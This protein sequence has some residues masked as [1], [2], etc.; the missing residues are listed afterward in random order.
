MTDDLG[1]SETAASG[2]NQQGRLNLNRHDHPARPSQEALDLMG[3]SLTVLTSKQPL[4]ARLN[5]LAELVK[6]GLHLQGTAF[7][8]WDDDRETF[9]LHG[10]A[11]NQGLMGR[12]P[13]VRQDWWSLFQSRQVEHELLPTPHDLRLK[14]FNSGTALTIPLWLQNHF[15]GV[16]TVIRCRPEQP[17]FSPREINLAQM[18]AAQTGLA[19]G[20][21]QLNHQYHR[22]Q[23]EAYVAQTLLQMAEDIETLDSQAE[24]LDRI[25]LIISRALNFRQTAIFLWDEENNAYHLA[26]ATGLPAQNRPSWSALSLSQQDLALW[27]LE[28]EERTI[29]KVRADLHTALVKQLEGSFKCE[30]SRLIPLIVK[31]KLLGV[32]VAADY[33]GQ[34]PYSPSTEFFLKGIGTQAAIALNDVKLVEAL[35]RAFWDVIKSL[36]TTIEAKDH[37]THSHSQSVAIYGTSLA[38]AL[39]LPKKEVDKIAKACLLHDLGKIGIADEILQ[40]QTPL[41]PSERNEINKHPVIGEMILNTVH[42]FNDIA[43]LV[44]HHHE[45]VDGTGYPEQLKGEE[46]PLYARII[47]IADSFDAMTS[48]R[49]YRK[50]MSR[51]E[52]MAEL[53]AHAGHQF[54]KNLVDVFLTTLDNR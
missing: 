52:A 22:A 34:S 46:I 41:S 10:S 44:K 45:K 4:S 42:H 24:V 40:K 23:K 47:Q 6:S 37:Y 18:L 33:Q 7:Y 15:L 8:L 20:A 54:D 12:W 9:V 38:R 39:G 5:T 48:D 51:R 28:R 53:K 2:D 35:D 32:V 36:A 43:L 16:M 21:Q 1:N 27:A 14:D 50:A 25:L 11:L 26:K 17:S 19:V 13:V 29:V 31:N 49:P 3:R 30:D